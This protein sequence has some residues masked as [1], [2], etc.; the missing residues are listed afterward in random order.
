MVSEHVAFDKLYSQII[1]GYSNLHCV[2][3]STT[4]L[5]SQLIAATNDNDV[6]RIN[7]IFFYKQCLSTLRYVFM[8]YIKLAQ[9]LNTRSIKFVN[10]VLW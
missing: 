6:L 5:A 9:S 3:T 4:R 10:I 1:Y 2:Y 8:H 7:S